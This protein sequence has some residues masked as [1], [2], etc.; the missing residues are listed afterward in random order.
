MMNR[1]KKIEN[2]LVKKVLGNGGRWCNITM[3]A[4]GEVFKV[5]RTGYKSFEDFDCDS[6]ELLDE[7][8]NVLVQASRPL[9][10]AE[11]IAARY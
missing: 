10:I 7:D 2:A 3:K 4:T 8:G 11:Y 1:V 5:R 9:E 6:C